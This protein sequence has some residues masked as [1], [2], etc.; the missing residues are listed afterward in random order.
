LAPSP[1]LGRSSLDRS[2]VALRSDG[3][4]PNTGSALDRAD[5]LCCGR[6]GSVAQRGDLFGRQRA[7]G[8]TEREVV[9]ERLLALVDLVTAVEVEEVHILE[10][11]PCPGPQGRLDSCCRDGLVDD[12]RHVAVGD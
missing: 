3:N 7:P 8:G 10:R 11:L 1:C 4:E 5:L 2:A 6:D 9:P 12:E